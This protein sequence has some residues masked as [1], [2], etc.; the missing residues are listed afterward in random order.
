MTEAHE[1]AGARVV[2]ARAELAVALDELEDRF[3][4][5]KRARAFKKRMQA[6]YRSNP[7]V[8]IAGAAGAAAA[9]GLLVWAA[10]RRASR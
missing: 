4:L 1:D 8:W 10:V 3:N 2:R 5:P 7:A 9:V 6:S